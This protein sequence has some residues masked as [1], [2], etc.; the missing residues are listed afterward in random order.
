[1]PPD[2][3]M[4]YFPTY[5]IVL[6]LYRGL[7]L[8]LN[9]LVHCF[10]QRQQSCQLSFLFRE[11]WGLVLCSL[12]PPK[13]VIIDTEVHQKLFQQKQCLHWVEVWCERLDAKVYNHRQNTGQSSWNPESCPKKY[14][15]AEENITFSLFY[16]FAC[17][18]PNHDTTTLMFHTWDKAPSPG[19]PCL[20]SFPAW[21]NKTFFQL[22]FSNS[23]LV[24]L[25]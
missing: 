23:V 10:W 24:F 1:M 13:Y 9:G 3:R 17:F 8:S 2:P 22:F 18:S 25:I 15:S 14:K 12:P 21:I 11:Q 4:W 20:I 7:L 19:I 6:L 5:Y 16:I